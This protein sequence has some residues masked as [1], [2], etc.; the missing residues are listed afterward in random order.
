MQ[1]KKDE[2]E[3]AIIT[4]AKKEF[5]EKG[6]KDTSLRSIS[7]ISGVSLSNIY[8]YFSSKDKLF[9]RILQP[10]LIEITRTKAFLKN[11][12][13]DEKT[14]SM[15]FHLEIL[16]PVIEFIDRN[17]DLLKLL[18]MNS[19]GSSYENFFDDFTEWYTDLSI[20]TIENICRKNNHDQVKIN[21]FVAHNLIAFWVQFL[22]ESLMHNINKN[23]LLKYAKDLMFFT[24]SGWQGL[25]G[26]TR[27]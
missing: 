4:A 20:N 23:E 13:E 5:I 3:N 25:M 9:Q 21:R 11:H 27:E 22:R 15:E 17:R 6:Y 1:I 19:Y 2:I 8:N 14:Y 10:V 12:S 16:E 18:M 7:K 24:Y 26:T